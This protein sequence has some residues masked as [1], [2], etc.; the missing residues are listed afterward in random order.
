MS[1]PH[2]M[3]TLKTAAATYPV[4]LAQAKE[5]LRLNSVSFAD[6]IS[7]AQTI[8]AGDQAI[9]ANYTLV[10]SAVDILGYQAAAILDC[11]TFGAGGTVDVKL[12]HSH[13]NVTWVDASQAF[14]TVTTANDNAAY[15]LAYTG[16]RRYIR[17][18]A[19][20]ANATCDFGVLII[21]DISTT[22]E[23]TFLDTLI[24]VATSHTENYLRR[25]L[26]TQTWYCWLDG[27]PCD[28]FIL[29]H[30]PI[31]SVT[32]ITYY[33]TEDTVAT[34]ASTYYFVDTANGRIGLNYGDTWP[35]STLRPINGV[36]IEFVAGY[37]AAASVPTPIYQAMLLLIGH[38]Y[39]QRE[40]TIEAAL[41]KTPM[42]YETLLYPYRDLRLS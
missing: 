27:W 33:D 28:P 21:K 39:E 10:G 23:D 37:G 38:L 6:D 19:T 34:F 35:T 24:T 29:G 13:D 9:A 5:H 4:S 8:A 41:R 42:A 7:Q 14:T 22:Q 12:Q 18:V 2:L 17:A 3:Y 16:T 32:A 31:Q 1:N 25:S 11:G 15:E 20:V 30:G 40:A 36:C 26:I